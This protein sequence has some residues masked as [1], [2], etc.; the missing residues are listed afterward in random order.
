MKKKLDKGKSKFLSKMSK[1]LFRNL[2][3]CIT[4]VLEFSVI[5]GPA[6][7]FYIFF[8]FC[9]LYICFQDSFIYLNKKFF[10]S[11]II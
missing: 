11:E 1:I 5:S 10:L 4:A 6:N 8:W 7:I 3:I 2:K 9:D